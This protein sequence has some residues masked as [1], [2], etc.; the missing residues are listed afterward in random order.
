MYNINKIATINKKS[1]IY[2]N[3]LP[4]YHNKVE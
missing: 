1:Y 3:Y 2:I 4:H